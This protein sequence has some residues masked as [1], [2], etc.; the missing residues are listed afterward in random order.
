[1]TKKEEAKEAEEEDDLGVE[2]VLTPSGAT[3]YPKKF[4]EM[5]LEQLLSGKRK[6]A[7]LAKEYRLYTSII[8]NWKRSYLKQ[9]VVESS[10]SISCNTTKEMLEAFQN[11]ENAEKKE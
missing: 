11:M 3:Y 8:N 6:V 4:K 5:V 7:H 9:K 1:M 2:Q 10:K